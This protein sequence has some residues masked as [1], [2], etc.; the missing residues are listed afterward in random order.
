MP[1][2]DHANMVL[3]LLTLGAL[4][5]GTL[6]M[7]V[8]WILRIRREHPTIAHDF[9]A[10]RARR[11]ILNEQLLPENELVGTLRC[12]DDEQQKRKNEWT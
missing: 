4:G 3:T 5:L 6:A 2:S 12:A 7:L 8:R 10:G 9:V 1:A 11:R